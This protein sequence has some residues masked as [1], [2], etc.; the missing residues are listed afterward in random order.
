MPNNNQ[1]NRTICTSVTNNF[2]DILNNF[3]FIDSLCNV[4]DALNKIADLKRADAD[5]D[6]QSLL[7]ASKNIIDNL[8]ARGLIKTEL[9]RTS[10]PAVNTFKVI[11]YLQYVSAPNVTS[12]I[13][14][15][16]V[17]LSFFYTVNSGAT[18]YDPIANAVTYASEDNADYIQEVTAV[19]LSIEKLIDLVGSLKDSF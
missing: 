12:N 6:I 10:S 14:L 1:L 19:K 11:F 2:N 8:V 5:S 18:D 9:V 16:E 17:D 4:S 15:Y 13:N 7:D 3:K